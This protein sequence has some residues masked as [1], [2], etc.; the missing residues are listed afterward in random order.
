MG[1]NTVKVFIIV[2]MV[3]NILEI[4]S[5]VKKMAKDSYFLILE[6]NIM[7]NG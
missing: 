3:I 5:K 2:L 1:K 6:I 4:I 7:V